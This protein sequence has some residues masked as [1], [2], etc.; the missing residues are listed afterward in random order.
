M[1]SVKLE[2]PI[3][4]PEISTHM[5]GAISILDKFKVAFSN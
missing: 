5:Q 1:L 3:S 2:I 4:S